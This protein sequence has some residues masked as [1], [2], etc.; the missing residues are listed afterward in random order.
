M[1]VVY[2]FMVLIRAATFAIL[3]CPLATFGYGLDNGWKDA[4]VGV[5]AVFVVLSGSSSV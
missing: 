2:I 5:W 1:I 3:Y 4:F